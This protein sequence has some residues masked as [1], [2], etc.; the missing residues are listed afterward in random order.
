MNCIF[1]LPFS[2]YFLE[3]IVVVA[4]KLLKNRLIVYEKKK[5]LCL[6]AFKTAF[7]KERLINSKKNVKICLV[8]K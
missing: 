2:F 5:F 7:E 6:N 3:V 1:I 8:E 4:V